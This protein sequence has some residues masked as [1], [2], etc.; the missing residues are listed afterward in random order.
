MHDRRRLT[1]DLM[2]L[3]AALA[4]GSTFVP[5]KIA[6]AY[7]GP[8][9]F[10]GLRFLLGVLFVLI[11][12]G[13]RLRGLDRREV[14]GG[15]L[16]GVVLF[17]AAAL[18]QAGLEFTTAG[19]AGFITGLYVVLVPLFLTGVRQWPGWNAWVAST[20]AATGLFLL[21]GEG[22]WT[23]APGD[24]MVL[25]AA[26]LYA[27]HVILIGRM[28][29]RADPLRLSVVQYLACGAASLGFGL[30]MEPAPW[31]ALPSVWWTVLYTAFFSIVVGYTFQS[32][33]QRYAPPTDAAVILSMESVFAAL[34]G[35]LLL[36][37]H[38][39]PLQAVGGGLMLAGMILAQVRVQWPHRGVRRERFAA[40]T[41]GPPSHLTASEI[42]PDL[43]GKSGG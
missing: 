24:G 1:A 17:A 40:A 38:L 39:S 8:L 2:L 37:E 7:M 30:A 26:A 31:D 25:V 32:L 43:R 29:Q 12:T 15:A 20:L 11:G 19:K 23:L 3:A 42:S 16:A 35:V 13:R 10:N 4:W 21:S 5:C 18:Q 27:V 36:G 28:V 22:R 41:A 6:T 34:F 14:G 33:A 9:V